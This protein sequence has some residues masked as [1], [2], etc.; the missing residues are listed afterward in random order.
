MLL[1]VGYADRLIMR[2]FLQCLHF[3]DLF[4]MP[5]NVFF[6]IFFWYPSPNF[7]LWCCIILCDLVLFSHSL[8]FMQPKSLNLILALRFLLRLIIYKMPLV[9]IYRLKGLIK[10]LLQLLVQ[11]LNWTVHTQLRF[12]FQCFL[13][14]IIIVCLQCWQYLQQWDNLCIHQSLANSFLIRV[15][16]KSFW[17]GCQKQNKIPEG[18]TRSKLQDCRNLLNSYN[19]RYDEG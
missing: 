6:L 8:L 9:P 16:Y 1:L 10:M 13:Y 17:R 3:T 5:Y 12:D 18:F 11:H 2:E 4:I 15:I 14:A 7:C 19:I